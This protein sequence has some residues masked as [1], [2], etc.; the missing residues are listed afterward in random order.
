MTTATKPLAERF[1]NI[2]KDYE[3]FTDQSPGYDDLQ[4]AI[5]RILG[6]WFTGWFPESVLEFG[7]GTGER[8]VWLFEQ[9]DLHRYTGVDFSSEML[10]HCRERADDAAAPT[11]LTFRDCPFE[12]WEPRTQYDFVF[13]AL[14]L[15][16]I[17]RDERSEFWDQVAKALRPDGRLLLADVVRGNPAWGRSH[18][19]I[20]RTLAAEEGADLEE[21]QERWRDHLLHDR[22]VRWDRM[23]EELNRAGF[24]DV[25]LA[26]K[27]HQYVVLQARAPLRGADS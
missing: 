15:H 1:D 2:A 7:P 13:S 20:A 9:L 23:L 14:S 3:S 19:Q 10:A 18:L 27:I 21:H 4:R 6:A 22:P 12:E 11:D 17:P 25:E 16:H 26:Y 24:R 5:T 8:M